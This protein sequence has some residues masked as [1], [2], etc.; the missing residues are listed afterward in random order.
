MQQ[1]Q[2]DHTHLNVPS[3]VGAWLVLGCH[4]TVLYKVSRE[5]TC[6]K[7][8]PAQALDLNQL[9]YYAVLKCP[10]SVDLHVQDDG[11]IVYSPQMY[12][13]LQMIHSSPALV[14]TRKGFTAYEPQQSLPSCVSLQ[15]SHSHFREQGFVRFRQCPCLRGVCEHYIGTIQVLYSPS[16]VR[17]DR[18]FEVNCFFRLQNDRLAASILARNSASCAQKFLLVD[19]KLKQVQ[20]LCFLLQYGSAQNGIRYL[21]A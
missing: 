13:Y 9:P 11:A 6:R 3:L 20:R 10:Q 16:F 19:S 21:C 15:P 1:D 18:F 12:T 8:Q 14:A 7:N 2:Q 17:R 4:Q 5:R